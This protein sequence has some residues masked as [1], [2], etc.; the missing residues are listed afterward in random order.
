MNAQGKL[1]V[2]GV[3]VGNNC[4]SGKPI[5]YRIKNGATLKAS[6]SK[7]GLLQNVFPATQSYKK[8]GLQKFGCYLHQQFTV[9]ISL[10]KVLV[11]SNQGYFMSRTGC[12]IPLML[13]IS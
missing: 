2:P 5:P 9:L 3:E 12:K 13:S 10:R 7:P 1:V 6:E 4:A 11:N 8:S